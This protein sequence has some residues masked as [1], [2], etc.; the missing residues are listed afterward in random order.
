MAEPDDIYSDD[1]IA[2]LYDHFNP[3]GADNAFYLALARETGGPVIDLG[4]GTGLAA[5]R[6]AEE[7]FQVVGADPSASMLAVARGRPGAARVTWVHA[8]GQDLDRPERF[9]LVYMTGHAFQALLTDEAAVALLRNAG[10]HLAPG[11]R[12]AFETRN[13]AVEEWRS[14][15]P[16]EWRERAEI[17]GQGRVEETGD[18]AHD[19]TTGIV[20]IRHLYRYLDRGLERR[21]LSRIRF[22]GKSH[23]ARLI[24]EA[25]LAPLAFY[26]CWDRSPVAPESREIIA[27]LGRRE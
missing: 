2:R 10:R 3:W 11:G 9:G 19:P 6:M 12:L 17:P 7:G 13:P 26:G 15:S 8:A 24:E 5:V 18:A 23:L 27:V 20:T 1:A 4:C 16:A 14:W 21:A 25:G 22:I